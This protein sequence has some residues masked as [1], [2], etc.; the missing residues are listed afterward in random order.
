MSNFEM[1]RNAKKDED[2]RNSSSQTERTE[3]T[4]NTEEITELSFEAMETIAGGGRC[5][6]HLN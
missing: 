4:E 2:L 3:Q 6:W 5:C 1:T